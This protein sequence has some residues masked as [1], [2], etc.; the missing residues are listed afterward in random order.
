[1]AEWIKMSLSMELALGPGDFVQT[2]LHCATCRRFDTIPACDR[3]T[4]M[5]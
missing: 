5:P 4:E 3:Q 2:A 1:M